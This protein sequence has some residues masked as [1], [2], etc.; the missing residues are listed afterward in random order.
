MPFAASYEA[1]QHAYVKAVYEHLSTLRPRSAV[2]WL[3]KARMSR[4]NSL[5][6]LAMQVFV[7]FAALTLLWNALIAAFLPESE[8][9]VC[10]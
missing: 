1:V 10:I 6:A 2:N 5:M 3:C 7:F 9:A 8:H 4:L